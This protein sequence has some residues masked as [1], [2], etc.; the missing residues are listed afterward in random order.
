[1]RLLYGSPLPPGLEGPTR[2]EL[3][4]RIEKLLLKDELVSTGASSDVLSAGSRPYPIPIDH[5]AVS[6][7]FWGEQHPTCHCVPATPGKSRGAVSL[8]YPLKTYEPQFREYLSHMSH[9]KHRGVQFSVFVPS[10]YSGR[11]R[12]ISV[13][14]SIIA[15]DTL[16]PS[17]PVSGWF[18]IMSDE[19]L[20]LSTIKDD[21][22]NL[23][24]SSVEVG[25]LRMTFTVNFFARVPLLPERQAFRG[26]HKA[27]YD[28]R[29][30][31]EKMESPGMVQDRGYSEQ[32]LQSAQLL[33]L[34]S[35][36]TGAAAESHKQQSRQKQEAQQRVHQGSDITKM[37][38][39]KL[40]MSHEDPV[41]TAG[42]APHQSPSVFHPTVTSVITNQDAVIG[43]LLQRGISLR[44]KMARVLSH[45]TGIDDL[46]SSSNVFSSQPLL[47]MLGDPSGYS[48]PLTGVVQLDDGLVIPHDPS[49]S[50]VSSASVETVVSET[51]ELGND[52]DP[53]VDAGGEKPGTLCDVPTGRRAFRLPFQSPGAFQNGDIYVEVDLSRIAFSSGQVT[54]GMEEMRVGIRLSKDVKTDEP[55]ESYSSY[56]HRVPLV[57]G[58]EHHI[59][60]GFSVR[61][62]SED[63]SRMVISFYRVR[64]APVPNPPGEILLPVPASA[65]RVLVE[66]TLLGMCIVGLHN[67]FRDIALHDPITGEDPTQAHLRVSIRRGKS[68][69]SEDGFLD[70]LPTKERDANQSVS[71]LEEAGKGMLLSNT[72]KRNGFIESQHNTNATK[73]TM[74]YSRKWQRNVAG[75]SFS[76]SSASLSSPTSSSSTG[77]LPPRVK[78]NTADDK[79][80]GT[81]AGGCSGASPEL[82][83]VHGKCFSDSSAAQTP[84]NVMVK[85]AALNRD[86][87]TSTPK[88]GSLMASNLVDGSGDEKAARCANTTAMA[89]PYV[90]RALTK[91]TQG[92]FRMHVSI[93]AGKEL[94]MVTISQEGTTLR[95]LVAAVDQLENGVRSAVTSDGRLV[96][97][98]SKHRVFK[99]PTTFFVVEDV[100]NGIDSRA[101]SKGIVPDW[102]VEAAVRG[103][104]DRTLIIP[105]SQSPQY[106]YESVLSLPREAV[107]L[108]HAVD[109]RNAT[110][111]ET[112]TLFPLED[113]A[114]NGLFCLRELRL[115]LWHTVADTNIPSSS[116]WKDDEE[117]FWVHTAILGEC[118]V[119]LRSLRF[120]KL[121]DGWYRINAVDR[122]DEVV[123]Y[124]RVSVRML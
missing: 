106:D 2:G 33:P 122:A 118:R 1:M 32:E 47:S 89:A 124:V 42:D 21:E 113:N 30:R 109:S 31:E 13:G 4:I 51:D 90:D 83:Y 70:E 93:R 77:D 84:R 107:F 7:L 80:N 12:S 86:Q 24:L 120:L 78:V 45:S 101:A 68:P 123:G 65:Q 79:Q 20:I 61:S 19:A 91:T 116:T 92:R 9:S 110:H 85:E 121:L 111:H 53:E 71:G 57:R 63:R 115:T 82:R 39:S 97:V 56:V 114:S 48:S 36:D 16:K 119:D 5:C 100:F 54:L 52:A 76:S 66:E 69:V 29:A 46:I 104:Y 75:R 95:P 22:K 117:R 62:F 35:P 8:V 15:L 103:K 23:S 88:M 49:E 58:A 10:S 60:I 55:V 44:D 6:P 99:A 87:H 64:S 3:R 17:S 72:K 28:Q 43:E 41:P 67:Q 74:R 25:R 105:E 73:S 11:H 27:C 50:S 59:V 40:P 37:E 94:P 96:L 81:G 108:R 38:V 112:S 98:D 102:F 34:V 14:K 18:A 26:T